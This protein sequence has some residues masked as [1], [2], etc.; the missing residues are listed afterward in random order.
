MFRFFSCM[1]GQ[2]PKERDQ[3]ELIKKQGD[4]IKKQNE[5]L[6]LKNKENEMNEDI[7]N[8]KI[9][10]LEKTI[11]EMKEEFGN[12]DEDIYIST[13]QRKAIE[14]YDN[15]KTHFKGKGKKLSEQ[16]EEPLTDDEVKDRLQKLK[17]K[18]K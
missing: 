6:E 18:H 2:T 15:D 4:Y 5:K 8:K 14:D 12:I 13:L 1:F 3:S 16:G 9:E 10:E 17:D 7:K 11:E